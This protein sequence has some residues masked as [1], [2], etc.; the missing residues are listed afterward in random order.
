MRSLRRPICEAVTLLAVQTGR[1]LRV[2]IL[3]CRG[4]PARYGGFETFAE[5][6]SLGLVRQGVDVT[7]YAEGSG[8][9]LDHE[10][11]RVRY[12]RPLSLGPASVVAYDIQCLWRARRSVDVVY[13]LG[14][15]AAW[16]CFIPRLWGTRVWVNMDGLEWARSKWRP[17]VKAYFRLMERVMAYTVDRVLADAHAIKQYYDA[18]Y[19]SG[20]PCTFIP[21]GAQGA[22][23]HDAIGPLARHGLVVDRYFL[24]V[25][26][27]EPENHIHEIIRAHQRW[28]GTCPLVVIGDH[29]ADNAY[30]RWI[31]Q[32]QSP[33]VLLLGAIY[34]ADRL[35]ALRSGALAYV[36]GH[37]VGGTNPSLL[38]AMWYAS[39]VLAHDNPFN[40]E[41][42]GDEG[43]AFASE[44]V[45]V[46]L[47]QRVCDMSPA[48]RAQRR[49]RTR[50]I[51]L[52]RY[53]WPLVVTDYLALLHQEVGTLSAKAP[54]P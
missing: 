2:A 16:G 14:Y 34:E 33:S 35:A 44:E 40:R 53:Q 17:W 7:V 51:V 27:M 52:S 25:A 21:Y 32:Q 26:R 41:V 50:Q 43:L 10:G 24:V 18:R 31:R 36:H 38:E 1:P 3:G 47:F 48:D 49:Q 22:P 19:P 23:V 6:L 37:S 11:V 42:L 12:V 39:V 54:S 15:G 5:Q 29:T 8:P 30:C 28:G 9:D 20:A 4:I 46:G 45:L 13:M